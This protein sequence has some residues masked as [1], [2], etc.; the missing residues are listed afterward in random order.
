LEGDFFITSAELK[1][2]SIKKEIDA[3]FYLL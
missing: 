1:R 2:A 3:L